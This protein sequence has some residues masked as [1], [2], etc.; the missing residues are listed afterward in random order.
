M[1]NAL[2]LPNLSVAHLVGKTIP[3]D[4]AVVILR[5]GQPAR[6][7][8]GGWVKLNSLDETFGP[9][10]SV[11]PQLRD[12]FFE[13]VRSKDS[14]PFQVR[15]EVEYWF[16]PALLPPDKAPMFTYR[17][18][19]MSRQ[20]L[21]RRVSLIVEHAT[22]AALGRYPA[23]SLRRGE[24]QSAFR[25]VIHQALNGGAMQAGFRITPVMVETY[26][27][28]LY[29]YTMQVQQ[30]G[31]D[32][33]YLALLK[34]LHVAQAMEKAQPQVHHLSID[35]NVKALADVVLQ[36]LPHLLFPQVKLN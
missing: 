31:L 24:Y 22:R 32:R 7:A 34:E 9:T 28:K 15:V 8:G 4:Q 23:S 20:Q 14:V 2:N 6:V 26:P 21:E 12:F 33:E 17:Y 13:N 5:E 19:T 16:D 18:A 35:D 27:P 3:P 36:A 30:L 1:L 25:G 11:A 10:L 29:E